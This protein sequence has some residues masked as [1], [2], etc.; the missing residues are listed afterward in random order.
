MLDSPDMQNFRDNVLWVIETEGATMSDLARRADIN[1]PG[2]HNMLHGKNACTIPHGSKISAAL[3]V[4]L[5]ELLLTPSSFQS[6][7][8]SRKKKILQSA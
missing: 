1:R 6:L 3:G 8:N 2:L 5:P 4:T 7:Y